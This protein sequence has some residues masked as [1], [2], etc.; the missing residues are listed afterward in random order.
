[1]VATAAVV[2][3]PIGSRSPLTVGVYLLDWLSH[4][5]G[6]VRRVTYEGYEVLIRR[7]AL[8]VLGAVELAELS[9]LRLQQLYGALL[10]G[11]ESRRALSGGTVL[12]LH[13]VLTQ[14]FSQAVRWQLLAGTLRV[15]CRQV[16]GRW[17]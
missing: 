17:P 3:S 6:R 11:S 16:T 2:A 7:H 14:A 13:L 8:P 1:M 5:R 10:E 9:P 12:N 4:V 15:P